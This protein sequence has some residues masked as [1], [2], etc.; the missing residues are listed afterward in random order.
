LNRNRHQLEYALLPHLDAGF[1]LAR[2]LLNDEHEARD[3]VQSAC[4]RALR[5]IDSLKGDDARAWFL[6]I[7]RNTCFSALSLRS[8]RRQDI[9]VDDLLGSPAELATLGGSADQP[10][11]AF[12]R[13]A[14]REQVNG[15]LKN[16]SAL[17]R[18]VLIL[19]EMEELSY[20]EIASVIDAPLGTVMSRLA[21]ARSMFRSE[22]KARDAGTKHG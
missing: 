17:F 11:V 3:A 1:N 15:A 16:M 4:E 9:D 13:A 2:W 12:E 21:R 18:E 14:T 19:R 8:G 7:V 5:Y 22:L 10:D 20:A 6:G